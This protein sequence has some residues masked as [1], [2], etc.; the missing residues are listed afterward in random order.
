MSDAYGKKDWRLS[1]KWDTRR[2]LSVV[3]GKNF[4]SL[5]GLPVQPAR[6]EREG[7]PWITEKGIQYPN[8]YY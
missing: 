5:V 1:C 3:T 7:M 8:L 4:L 2:A 6:G